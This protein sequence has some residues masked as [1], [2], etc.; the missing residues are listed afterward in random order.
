[1]A[2]QEGALG[3][4]IS[5]AGPAIVAL[6]DE[7]KTN[8]TKVINAMKQGFKNVDLNTDDYVGKPGRGA[9]ITGLT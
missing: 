8:P 7:R 2:K 5:G 4:T 1:M 6:V 3:V 9:V